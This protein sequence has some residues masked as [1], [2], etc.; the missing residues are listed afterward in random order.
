MFPLF[1]LS[2][3]IPL[4]PVEPSMWW[5]VER[6]PVGWVESFNIDASQQRV[7]VIVSSD[8]WNSADYLERFSFLRRLGQE[9]Q[10]SSYGVLLVNTRQEKLAEYKLWG[11][12]WVMEPDTLGALPFRRDTGRRR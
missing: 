12:G 5:I 10:R 1:G 8:R 9:A 3:P 7:K 2:L 6:S 11:Q 4:Q